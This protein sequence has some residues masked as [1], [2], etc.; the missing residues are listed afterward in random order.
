MLNKPVCVAIDE[1][2]EDGRSSTHST[3]AWSRRAVAAP[4]STSRRLA[5]LSAVV[6]WEKCFSAHLDLLERATPGHRQSARRAPPR[7]TRLG[8][9]AGPSPGSARS[10]QIDLV[11]ILGPTPTSGGS[12]TTPADTSPIQAYT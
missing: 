6:N 2:P 7:G 4:G 11:C 5:I 1:G 12:G 9:M 8:L 10:I 3:V